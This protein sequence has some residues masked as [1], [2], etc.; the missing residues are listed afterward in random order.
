M[1]T[2]GYGVLGGFAVPILVLVVVLCR[3]CAGISTGYLVSTFVPLRCV[4][5]CRTAKSGLR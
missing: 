2:I 5:F 3:S 4:F 1:D